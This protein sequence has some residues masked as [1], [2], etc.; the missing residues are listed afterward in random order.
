MVMRLWRYCKMPALRPLRGHACRASCGGG[1]EYIPRDRNPTR[2]EETVRASMMIFAVLLCAACAKEADHTAAD[3]PAATPPTATGSAA[4]TNKTAGGAGLP[5]GY[6]GRVDDANTSIA[7]ARYTKQGDVWDVTTGPQVSHIMWAPGDTARGN[8]TVSSRFQQVA[9]PSHREAY[10]IFVG[11]SNLD[12]PTQKY[13]YFVVGGTG[14]YLINTRDGTKVTKIRDWTTSASVPK[15]DASGKA[16]SKLAIRVAG[17]S[18]HFMVNDTQVA[19]LP[20][21]RFPTDG[22]AGIRIGHN[23]HLQVQPISISR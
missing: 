22:I 20:K 19:V 18:V 5:A 21:S 16:D 11:G 10:G 14:E 6:L 17:D 7:D 4:D 9:A 3:S 12:Q 1:G 23:L 15:Q 2:P 13:S 8:F